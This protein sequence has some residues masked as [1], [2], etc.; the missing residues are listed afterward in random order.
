[1]LIQQIN[2]ITCL[3]MMCVIVSPPI[4]FAGNAEVTEQSDVV[5]VYR[6]GTITRDEYASWVRYRKITEAQGIDHRIVT[7]IAVTK[8]LAQQALVAGLDATTE[9]SVRLF[10]EQSRYLQRKLKQHLF[11]QTRVPADELERDVTARMQK[12]SI[13]RRVKLRNLFLRY[14]NTD[15]SEQTRKRMESIRQSI[16]EGADFETMALEHSDSQTRFRGGL[17]GVV[18]VGDLHPEVEAVA[19]RLKAG[20]ISSIMESVDGLTVLQCDQ[21]YEAH[22]PTVDEVRMNTVSSLRRKLHNQEWKELED[23]WRH[24]ASIHLPA[25]TDDT[26]V[27]VPVI[28][29]LDGASLTAK[30][31]RL[32]AEN[33]GPPIAQQSQERLRAKADQ[34][35]LYTQAARQARELGLHTLPDHKLHLNWIRAS[36]LADAVLD[37][38]VAPGVRPSETAMR[39]FFADH[40]ERFI[41]PEAFHLEGIAVGAD[42]SDVYEKERALRGLRGKI[43]NGSLTFAEAARMHSELPSSDSG[44][45]LGWLSRREIAALGPNILAAVTELSMEGQI[46]SVVQQNVQTK[47]ACQLWLLRFKGTRRA[48][49]LTF[50]EARSGIERRLTREAQEEKKIQHRAVVATAI[51]IRPI[52]GAVK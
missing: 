7:Q 49:P 10:S 36:M 34:I 45:A 8:A 37:Q 28:R 50:E 41:L 12:A 11:S 3:C 48:R 26:A 24:A 32:L 38:Q 44:G 2:Q 51:D 52:E 46:T 4:C 9:I 43:L 47:R 19:M 30:A 18:R 40:P 5:A 16:L 29:F 42:R 31:F 20:E 13:P 25:W 17:I 35:V 1:M 22:Q 39:A 33:P 14:P 15:E 27:D 23:T 21:V 6:G